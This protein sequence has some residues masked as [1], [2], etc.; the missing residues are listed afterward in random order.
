MKTLSGMLLAVGLLTPAPANADRALSA[1]Y[2]MERCNA[3]ASDQSAFDPL[4][5][6]F[7]FG[8]I[9][10]FVQAHRSI[11]VHLGMEI[12]CL[13]PDVTPEQI[14]LVWMNYAKQ[15]PAELHLDAIDPFISSM[16][17]AFPCPDQQ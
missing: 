9:S 4:S 13:P 12:F 14:R 3:A 7:C 2:L 15:N 1:L 6:G 8:S 10:G 11:L 5:A 17:D 16:K